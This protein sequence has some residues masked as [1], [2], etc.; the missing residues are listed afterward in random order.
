MDNNDIKWVDSIDFD[1]LYKDI[2]ISN[3]VREFSL[4]KESLTKSLEEKLNVK[5]IAEIIS[6]DDSSEEDIWLNKDEAEKENFVS[7]CTWLKANKVKKVFAVTAC[8]KN[9][10]YIDILKK[11]NEPIGRLLE[12]HNI[13]FKKSEIEF[14]IIND[15]EEIKKELGKDNDLIARRYVMTLDSYEF[16]ND[17]IYIKEIYSA[18]IF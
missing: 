17:K 1:E 3:E 18:N 8:N 16:G 12:N 2:Q 15:N 7:R 13:E 9:S 11:E 14:S 6:I 4:S 10:N 5:L